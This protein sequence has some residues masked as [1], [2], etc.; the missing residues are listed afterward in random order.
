MP[1]FDAK[2]DVALLGQ[3]AREAGEIALNYY[4]RDPEVWTKGN[5]SPVSEADLAVDAFL[6]EQLCGARPDYGWLSEETT[7]SDD[8]LN[9]N[10]VFI[11]DPI[12]GTRAFIEGGRDWTV[13]VAVVTGGRPVAAALFAPVHGEMFL[14]GA[15]LGM[16]LN[17]AL[18]SAGDAD[19]LDGARIAGPRNILKHAGFTG[20]GI[21][22]AG[23]IP[24]LA[25]RLALVGTQRLEA[26]VA[27]AR[28]HDWDLAAA[29]LIVHEAGGRLTD[30]DSRPIRYNT[31]NLR[32]PA[33]V[34][35]KAGLHAKLV[36]KLAEATAP[37]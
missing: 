35:S 6:R 4:K 2:S 16:T 15:G 27:R 18:T 30:T 9:R 32:H 24:S 19:T 3:A 1:D 7:D 37:Q 17:G 13:S 5:D 22:L 26:A 25:Y 14:A 12:D 10:H 8:R 36:D 11:V 33:L 20:T 29:D 34:A 28:S 21:K 31:E 23:F